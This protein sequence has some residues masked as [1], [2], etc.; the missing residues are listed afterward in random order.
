MQIGDHMLRV[1]VDLVPFGNEDESRPIAEMIIANDTTGTQD[2]GNYVFAMWSDKSGTDYGTVKDYY[3]GNGVF[4]L[5][6]ECVT[7]GDWSE[8]ELSSKLIDRIKNKK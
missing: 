2:F 5:I 1:T 6:A 3:R 8:H 4:E 7:N